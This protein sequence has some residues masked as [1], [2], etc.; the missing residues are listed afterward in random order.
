[1]SLAIQRGK[2]AIVVGAVQYEHL[3]FK[4][5][6]GTCETTLNARLRLVKNFQLWISAYSWICT[7]IVSKEQ[8]KTME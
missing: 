4:Q 1:M 6:F 5:V 7:L 8:T 3:I 2:A